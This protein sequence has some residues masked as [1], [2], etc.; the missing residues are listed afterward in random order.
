MN[1]VH[2]IITLTLFL[3]GCC[4][5]VLSQSNQGPTNFNGSNSTQVVNVQQNGTGFAL[6]ANTNSTGPVGAVYG[7]ASGTTG[8]SN[9]VWGRTFSN[10]GVGVRGEA[11]SPNG[12][13]GIAGFSINSRQGIGV[14]GHANIDGYGVAGVIDSQDNSGAGVFGQAGKSCCGIPGLFEQDA[15]ESGAYNVILMGQYLDTNGN[16]QSAFRVDTHGVFGYSINASPSPDGDKP[17]NLR[18]LEPMS[19]ASIAL[20]LYSPTAA[21]TPAA[22]TSRSLSPLRD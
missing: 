5:L 20:E 2:H 7:Q 13:T 16:L 6:K 14:Y 21:I 15:T 17:D 8:F 10:A 22:P 12:G 18:I 11:M 9:G 4:S 3:I 1:R 19:F